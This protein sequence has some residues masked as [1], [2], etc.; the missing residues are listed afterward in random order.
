MTTLIA[1][2]F[3]LIYGCIAT[4]ELASHLLSQYRWHLVSKP[5]ILLSLIIFFNCHQTPAKINKV[6]TTALVLCWIG[7]ILLMFA[8]LS[9]RFFIGGLV[10][11]LLAHLLFIYCNLE[12]R[13]INTVNSRD[14]SLKRGLMSIPALVLGV[15]MV[16]LIFDKLG[17]L[18]GPVIAYMVIIMLMLVQSTS[19]LGRTS[20]RS[21]WLIYSGSLFFVVS[22]SLLA[23]NKFYMSFP[24]A[25]VAIMSTYMLAVYLLVQGVLAHPGS[26][27]KK[28]L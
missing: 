7:D 3:D 25:Q 9:S 27:G 8:W 20:D 18:Q 12:L 4:V 5:A 26:S 11:F 2:N 13:F 16:H 24:M 19:R 22:D 6:F 23:V 15:G 28:I 10:S 1:K 21:F 17:S 14:T